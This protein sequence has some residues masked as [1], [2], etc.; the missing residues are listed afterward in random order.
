MFYYRLHNWFV[1]RGFPTSSRVD[2]KFESVVPTDSF[3]TGE[4]ALA[5]DFL[6]Q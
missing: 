6:H 4:S 2:F 3:K 5:K 1:F